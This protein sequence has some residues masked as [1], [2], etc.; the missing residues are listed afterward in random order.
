MEIISADLFSH[1]VDPPWCELRVAAQR[2]GESWDCCFAAC[3]VFLPM[4]FMAR[5]LWKTG[6]NAKMNWK[7]KFL[8][9][10]KSERWTSWLFPVHSAVRTWVYRHTMTQMQRDWPIISRHWMSF[11]IA[12]VDCCCWLSTVINHS[13]L[14]ILLMLIQYSTPSINHPPLGD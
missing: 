14:S 7:M 1:R 4:K 13:V 6:G 12:V 11:S 8:T 9:C 2:S 10:E 3:L 5:N